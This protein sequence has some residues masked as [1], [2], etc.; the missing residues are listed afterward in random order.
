MESA[1]TAGE[2]SFHF[3]FYIMMFS[4]Y[5]H[6]HNL[7]EFEKK[8][9]P[10]PLNYRTSCP[11]ELLLSFAISPQVLLRNGSRH[12]TLLRTHNG[13][14]V[15]FSYFY[16]IIWA[17]YNSSILK[18]KVDLY[19]LKLGS[20]FDR[21]YICL[22]SILHGYHPHITTFLRTLVWWIISPPSQIK[23]S[24]FLFRT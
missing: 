11:L 16:G 7:Y 1:R 8:W 19:M 5:L 14:F 4:L 6:F 3:W 18:E 24:T 12:R 13:V 15:T 10:E 2:L 20:Q 22:S 17:W 9:K 21:C 23:N